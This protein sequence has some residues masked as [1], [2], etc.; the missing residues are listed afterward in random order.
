MTLSFL[1]M[2]VA[3][4]LLFIAAMQPLVYNPPQ[5][6]RFN[7]FIWGMAIWALSIVLGGLHLH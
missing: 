6:S 7:L 4:V 2:I 3:T 5:P 1:L